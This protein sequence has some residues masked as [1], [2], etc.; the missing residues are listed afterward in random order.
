MWSVVYEIRFYCLLLTAW[1]TADIVFYERK[2]VRD[3]LRAKFSAIFC[4]PSEVS[5]FGEETCGPTSKT[6]VSPSSFSRASYD[7][8]SLAS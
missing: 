2:D 7:S 5:M 6:A 8:L 4:A 1:L 3:A